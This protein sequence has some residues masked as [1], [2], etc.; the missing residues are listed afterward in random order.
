VDVSLKIYP[1]ENHFLVFSRC[2]KIID[3]IIAWLDEH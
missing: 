2:D 3:D 1:G